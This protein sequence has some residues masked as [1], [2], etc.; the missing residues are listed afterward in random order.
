MKLKWYGHA[1]FRIT[2]SDG[3]TIITDPYTPELAGYA[4]FTETADIV[5]T[6]S[7][8]DDFHCRSDLIPGDPIRV[9]A[10]DIAK[11]GGSREI[12]GLTVLA[13]ITKEMEEHPYHAPEQNAMYRFEVDGIKV[14]HM[15]DIG[16]PF[17]QTQIDFL[18]GTD[19][20]LTLA[21]DVPTIKLVD[22]VP[23]L[24]EIAPKLIVP[25]HFR[26]LTYRPRDGFWI[27]SF[28]DHF[29]DSDVDFAFDYKVEL[30][31]GDIPDRT[32]V[33]VM[34]YVR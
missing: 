24:K 26:T 5:L 27:Q 18:K 12:N 8:D 25:M 14:A 33:L 3:T 10:L 30:T 28:L 16:N 13:T 23:A 9:N 4:P 1:A 32:R 21:G 7:D 31:A 17:T 29:D 15:G 6:S 20:L 11:E 34:D 22:L 19:V 2:A